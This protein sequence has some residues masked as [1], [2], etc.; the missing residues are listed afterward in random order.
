MKA[1]FGRILLVIAIFFSHMSFSQDLNRVFDG[2]KLVKVSGGFNVNQVFYTS[3]GGEQR[4][5][6]YNY[7]LTGSLSFDF[8]GIAVPLSFSYSNQNASFQQPFNQFSMQPYYKNFKGYVGYNSMSFSK[9]S[10]AG[11][12]FY[13]GGLEVTN[14]GKWNATGMYGRLRKAV[15]YDTASN[16]DPS[17]QR[18]GMGV[19]IGYQGENADFVNLILFS[20]KDDPTSITESLDSLELFAESNMVISVAAGKSITK[21]LLLKMEYAGSSLTRN[22]QLDEVTGN[23]SGLATVVGSLHETNASTE[24]YNALNSSLSYSGKTYSVG[25]NYER[26]DPGYETH[27]A[28]FFNNDLENITG[29]FAVSV[30]KSKVNIAVN[31]GLQKNN[32][33][34]DELSDFERWVGS[35]NVSYTP[36]PQLS[37]NGSYSNFQS[38]TN[39]RPSFEQI[40]DL[41]PFDN[42]DT[43]NFRQVSQNA[44]LNT[45]YILKQTK[46]NRQNLNVNLSYQVSTDNQ[47]GEEQNS[48]STF[49]NMNTAY[50][51]SIIPS[52]FTITSSVNGYLN[53]AATVRSTGLSPNISV[54][55]SFLDKKLRGS[56]ATTYTYAKTSGAKASKVFNV[57]LGLAYKLLKKHNFNLNVVTLNRGATQSVASLTETTATLTYNYNF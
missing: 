1:I 53:E 38:F 27:G 29:N 4:R 41:T 35:M 16:V 34:G 20:S 18:N 42:L 9:Y 24:F 11:H 51:Y 25:V 31:A 30:L 52:S 43:L 23:P 3:Y 48:G 32:L 57:R 49:Y 46:E 37:F 22:H 8:I 21:N 12:I 56:F 14:L 15:E 36:K 10:L 39:V 5:D 47:G 13:G 45:N 17:Y 33:N 26:I 44:N 54:S 19:K 7:F 28:Y 50:T 40:N 55:R 6:P 2:G